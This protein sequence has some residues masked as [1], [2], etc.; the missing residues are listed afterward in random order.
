MAWDIHPGHIFLLMYLSAISIGYAVPNGNFNASVHSAF[1][2]ALNLRLNA[3][4]PLLTMV[5]FREGDLPQG[6]RLNTPDGFSF[7]VI[8]IG[9][10]AFCRD[11]ILHFE[12]SPLT[13]QLNGARRWKCDLSA[14]RFDLANPAVSAAWTR[15]WETLNKR[16]R[17]TGSEIVAEDVFGL[18]E[19][20]PPGI[21]RRVRAAMRQLLLATRRYEFTHTSAV[22]SLIGLGAGLTPSGD[23]LLVGYM[24]GLWCTVRDSSK[25]AR[26]ISS[27]GKTIIQLSHR[28]NDISRTYL[29]HAVRGQVSSRLA[30]LAQAVCRG[31]ET[32][33]LHETAESAMS[34]GHT[35][36]MEAVSGLL[37]G[38]SAW[39]GG[40][41][42]R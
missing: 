24:A 20:T 41:L 38:L 2:S 31:D 19:S 12:S 25:R 22:D 23:D 37:V 13:I 16:Q 5:T 29:Y 26:Y 36:G 21:S 10:P 18:V 6:I 40:P 4:D 8:Q 34:V 15:V 14:L 28:T 3:E 9:K 30:D 27:L 32:V 11:G 39:E 1:Q 7:E 33:H 35:S 17:L 42:R